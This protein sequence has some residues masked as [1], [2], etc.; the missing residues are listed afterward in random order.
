M[1]NVQDVL[2]EIEFFNSKQYRD[3]AAAFLLNGNFVFISNASEVADVINSGG[4]PIC[5]FGWSADD[6]LRC[7]AVPEFRSAEKQVELL[8]QH[9]IHLIERQNGTNPV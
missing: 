7:R 6:K 1:P 5:V 3:V 2:K 4:D 8:Y 9:K